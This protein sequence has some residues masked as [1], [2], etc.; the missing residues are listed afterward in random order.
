MALGNELSVK[1]TSHASVHIH[2][3]TPP[4]TI[5]SRTYLCANSPAGHETRL[6]TRM[7]TLV[8]VHTYVVRTRGKTACLRV[9]RDDVRAIRRGVCRTY[10][11]PFAGAVYSGLG[12]MSHTC[13]PVLPA[14]H[15]TTFL[16]TVQPSCAHECTSALRQLRGWREIA[17]RAA[18]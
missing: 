8:Y 16:Q 4:G 10:K 14:K 11:R 6:K 18:A 17:R 3:T 2:G 13:Q 9:P 12:S 1:K 7:Y 15:V 5:L